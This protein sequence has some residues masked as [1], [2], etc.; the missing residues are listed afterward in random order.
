MDSILL[1]QGRMQRCTLQIVRLTA[2][3]RMFNAL[4]PFCYYVLTSSV[5]SLPRPYFAYEKSTY[6]T[7]LMQF[8][9]I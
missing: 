8:C 9:T 7:L 2:V 1:Q 5:R 3:E 4:F 6:G